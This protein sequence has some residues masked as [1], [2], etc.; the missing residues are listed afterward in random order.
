VS[1]GNTYDYFPFNQTLAAQLY[2]NIWGKGNC[3]D[4]LLECKAKGDNAQCSDADSFC[5]N[6][7]EFFF[8]TNTG[9]RDEYDM[10][11]LSPDPFPYGFYPAY[12]NKPE[13]QAAIGA[14]TNFS[15]FSGAVGTNFGLTGDD[16]REVDTIEDL[17]KLV[18]RNVTVAIYAGDADFI[19]NWLGN[20]VIADRVGAPHWEAAG[21]ANLSTSDGIVHGQVKQAGRFS[22]TR[23]FES[24]H[25]VPFYQPVAALEMFERAITGFD[26]A[27]GKVKPRGQ[28]C[29]HTKG[30]KKST[31]HQGNATMQWEVL[32]ANSTYN[33][34]TNSPGKPWRA[35]SHRRAKLI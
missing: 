2:D 22:F 26:I 11:E 16:G 9:G 3:T 1:P 21:Y 28:G 31:Y 17:G 7:A 13:V 4:Q 23:I 29:Y 18:A 8:D 12:L 27:T 15:E 25:E 10:R 6:Y 33:T 5:A 24:G 19:C 20:E 32:P 14:F 30:P 35:K 34:T